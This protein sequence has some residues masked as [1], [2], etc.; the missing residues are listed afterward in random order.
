MMSTNRTKYLFPYCKANCS[1]VYFGV[2]TK[3]DCETNVRADCTRNGETFV[4]I[5]TFLSLVREEDKELTLLVAIENKVEVTHE[6]LD[7]GV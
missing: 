6:T 5:H 2:E 4:C 1:E 7:C 3:E